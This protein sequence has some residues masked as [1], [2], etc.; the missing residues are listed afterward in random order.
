MRALLPIVGLAVCVL[1]PAPRA[2]AEDVALPPDSPF[3]SSAGRGD[4]IWINLRSDSAVDYVFGVDTG[5]TLTVLDTSWEHKMEPRP[6]QNITGARWPV[7]GVFAAPPLILGGVRLVTGQTVV[8]E[9]LAGHFPGHAVD[10]ILG[11]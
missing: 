4:I 6:T 11:M 5:A 10:G 8:T 3:N 1:M 2:W 7:S 9:D